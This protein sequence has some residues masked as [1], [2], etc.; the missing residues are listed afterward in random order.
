MEWM[1]DSCRRFAWQS[2]YAALTVSKSQMDRVRRYI[3]SQEEH[4]KRLSFQEELA[5]WLKAHAMTH[6]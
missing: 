6:E 2:G 5:Q 4:H 3:A 1:K